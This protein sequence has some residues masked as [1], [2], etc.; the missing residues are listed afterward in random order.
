MNVLE[1]KNDLHRLIVE[2]EDIDLLKE[3]RQLFNKLKSSESNNTK[4]GTSKVTPQ[5]PPE[6]SSSI[7]FKNG[8]WVY[9]GRLKKS[10][11]YV[12]LLEDAR[13]ER[14]DFLMQKMIE[15]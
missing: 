6:V 15:G 9:T 3:V 11:N 12:N 2:T 5:R 10:S 7:Q 14:A 4:R 13:N 8:G 1:L